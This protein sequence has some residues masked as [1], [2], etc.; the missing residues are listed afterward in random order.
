MQTHSNVE[1]IVV[2]DGSG[3]D[4]KAQLEAHYGDKI[5]VI[6]QDNQGVAHA[7]NTGI[8][9]STGD[10]I[11]FLD[12]DDIL[13]DAHV[14][15]D[16]MRVL[17]EHPHAVAV[18]SGWHRVDKTGQTLSAHT[19]WE[20]APALDIKEWLEHSPAL[21]GAML[22]RRSLAE[23]FLRF[24][25][26][27]NASDDLEFLLHLSLEGRQFVWLK[28]V[29]LAYCIHGENQSFNPDNETAIDQVLESVANHPKFPT[30]LQKQLKQRLYMSKVVILQNRLISQ[31]S[32]RTNILR[33]AKDLS[34]YRKSWD[35]LA[36]LQ[37][38][39]LQNNVELTLAHAQA[40]FDDLAPREL[41]WWYGVWWYYYMHRQ[42]QNLPIQSAHSKIVQ[43][44]QEMPHPEI[45]Q[46]ARSALLK[47]PYFEWGSGDSVE[48]VL[49]MFVDDAGLSK[50]E[51]SALLG[52]M[53][54]RARYLKDWRNVLRFGVGFLRYNPIYATQILLKMRPTKKVSD[55]KN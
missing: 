7:R 29:T 22:F 53:A 9:H 43:A 32:E 51:H 49:A 39:C 13:L 20:F 27:F 8:Q 16:W 14:Y 30:H 40:W 33:E 18:H 47:T 26:T 34:P 31:H 44:L 3:D 45:L 1:V 4:T 19:P 55:A 2:D 17:E 21:M 15:V 42:V 38:V 52:W 41:A 54:V 28:R 37:R 11:H 36:Q 46:Q 35:V 25:S 24:Y 6:T 50:A 12:H 48:K 5:K 23:P 10:Y